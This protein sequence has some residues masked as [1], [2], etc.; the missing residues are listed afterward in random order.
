MPPAMAASLAAALLVACGGG[1]GDTAPGTGNGGNGGT[2]GTGPGGGTG[3]G[4]GTTATP[5]SDEEAARFLLQAQ[6]SASD[7]EIAALRAKGYGA[8]LAEQFAQPVGT[9]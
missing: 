4:P 2:G 1:G 5:A 9:T 8:W 6:F 3:T 7:E